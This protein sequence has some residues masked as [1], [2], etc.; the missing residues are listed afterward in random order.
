[1]IKFQHH[2]GGKKKLNYY[3]ESEH[4]HFDALRRNVNFTEDLE[5]NSVPSYDIYY[6][7]VIKFC[8]FL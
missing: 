7:T 3:V 4:W 8:D 1:M 6:D 5:R 2:S